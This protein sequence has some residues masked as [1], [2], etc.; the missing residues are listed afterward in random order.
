MVKNQQS[1]TQTN[2]TQRRKYQRLIVILCC[3]LIG[4]FKWQ[5]KF[6][7][8]LREM[9]WPSSGCLNVITRCSQ[10]QMNFIKLLQI[11]ILDTRNCYIY[12]MVLA[13]LSSWKTIWMIENLVEFQ[14]VY[15]W[16]G[17]CLRNVFCTSLEIHL[18]LK[19]M[20]VFL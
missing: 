6:F 2:K 8:G 7:L 16:V 12:L 15:R 5:L 13:Q 14:C 1:H 18:G 9:R 20:C 19:C 11:I 4:N 10:S 3:E 17:E